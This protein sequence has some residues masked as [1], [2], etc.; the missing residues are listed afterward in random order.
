MSYL[1]R[2]FT[3][4]E[5]VDPCTFNKFGKNSFQFFGQNLL[6]TIDALRRHYDKP[7]FINTWNLPE[8]VWHKYG[9]GNWRWRGLRT[10]K[11][12]EGAPYSLHRFGMAVDFNIPGVPCEEIRKDIIRLR[13]DP[14]FGLITCTEVGIEGWVH[15]DFRNVP[16]F[17]TVRS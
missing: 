6:Y 16:E 5:L 17:M 14:T 2:H 4:D 9:F 15:I 10:D 13:T 3:A 11:C 1:P 12:Q 7:M 8:E